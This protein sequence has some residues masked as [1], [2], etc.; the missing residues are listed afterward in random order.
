MCHIW[1]GSGNKQISAMGNSKKVDAEQTTWKI[2][3]R[4]EKIL[5][6]GAFIMYLEA[7]VGL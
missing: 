2:L 3:S 5:I 1:T 6:G 4:Q 7:A